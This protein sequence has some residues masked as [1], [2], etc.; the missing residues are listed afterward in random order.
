MEAPLHYNLPFSTNEVNLCPEMHGI[1]N[2]TT[3]LES[4]TS[5]F[6]VLAPL[7][8][9]RDPRLRSKRLKRDTEK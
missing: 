8:L 4:K 3:C 7:E 5:L 6:N 1:I 2:M 9:K